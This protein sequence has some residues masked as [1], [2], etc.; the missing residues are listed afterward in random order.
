MCGA[1]SKARGASHDATNREKRYSR[2]KS[3]C[4]YHGNCAD[5]FGSAWVVRKALGD[6]D[7]FPGVY[8]TPP[9]D[10]AGREVVMV[11]FSYKRPAL[12]EMAKTAETILVI[13]HHKTAA[14]DLASLPVPN[15]D[16]VF[17]MEHSG[18]MLTWAHYFPDQEPP[19]L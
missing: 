17:D 2:M 18:A 14:E 8:M 11:D 12:L 6:V 1:R 9:P 5:G 7:F 3:L 10:V 16:A 15:I 13:D 19:Q 4:I